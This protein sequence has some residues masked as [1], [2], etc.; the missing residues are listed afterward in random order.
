MNSCYM[1]IHK[2]TGHYFG[3]KKNGTHIGYPKINFL[4]AAMTNAKV[5]KEDYMFISLSFDEHLRP[6][7]TEIIK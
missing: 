3:G 7:L 1:A 2:H 5:D 4:K 6:T